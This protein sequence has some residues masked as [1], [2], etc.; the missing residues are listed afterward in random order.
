MQRRKK[1]VLLGVAVLSAIGLALPGTA[2]AR[3][4]TPPLG[5]QNTSVIIVVDSTSST[6]S[7]GTVSWGDVSWGDVVS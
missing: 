6:S 5:V 1:T 7:T 2:A 4:Y 3:S